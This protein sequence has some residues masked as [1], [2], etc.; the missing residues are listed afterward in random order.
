MAPTSVPPKGQ[1]TLQGFFRPKGSSG[2]TNT[3]QK[4][5]S[6]TNESS[7]P[8]PKAETLPSLPSTDKESGQRWQ[9]PNG[10]KE[11]MSPRNDVS[12]ANRDEPGQSQFQIQDL[13]LENSAFAMK[14]VHDPIVSKEGWNRLFTKKGPPRCEDH[15]E[16]CILLTTK[17]AG[18]NCGRAF[19]ICPR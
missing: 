3:L 11:G 8:S 4:T 13:S 17:K 6:E 2:V 12:A 14:E 19:F 10:D 18:I 15:G 5:V 7:A 16:P 9:H 1:K